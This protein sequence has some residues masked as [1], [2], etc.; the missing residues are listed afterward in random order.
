M[1]CRYGI[2]RH[3]DNMET[4]RTSMLASVGKNNNADNTLKTI[5]VRII[6]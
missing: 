5:I 1:V 4:M 2:V 3:N 6:Q